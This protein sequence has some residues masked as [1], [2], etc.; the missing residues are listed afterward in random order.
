MLKK[1]FFSL[2]EKTNNEVLYIM[3][4]LRL[5]VYAHFISFRCLKNLFPASFWQH[6][7]APE[8]FNLCGWKKSTTL[9]TYSAIPQINNYF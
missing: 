5:K 4:L 6:R 3:L 9:P 1:W 8:D 7:K 2:F